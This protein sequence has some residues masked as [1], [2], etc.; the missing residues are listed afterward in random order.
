MFCIQDSFYT[1][2]LYSGELLYK[3]FVCQIAFIAKFYMQVNFHFNILVTMSF[4]LKVLDTKELLSQ[5]F[6]YKGTYATRLYKNK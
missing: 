3:S 4:C 5:H 1:K 6:T 2:V